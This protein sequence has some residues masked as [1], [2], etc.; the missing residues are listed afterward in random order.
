[1]AENII[2]G[3]AVAAHTTDRIETGAAVRSADQ[4]IAIAGVAGVASS[5]IEIDHGLMDAVE[6]ASP[7]RA[8]AKRTLVGIFQEAS[9]TLVTVVLGVHHVGLRRSRPDH[10]ST[11]QESEKYG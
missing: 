9:V 6:R 7:I 3:T 5:A 10:G 2:F 11:Q 4:H 1:V 8:A